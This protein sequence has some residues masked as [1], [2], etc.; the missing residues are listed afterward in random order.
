VE[1]LSQPEVQQ[2]DELYLH[3]LPSAMAEAI[4]DLLH[5]HDVIPQTDGVK[6]CGMPVQFDKDGNIPV[7]VVLTHHTVN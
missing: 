1:S 3:L 7:L 4:E 6:S 2:D 5:K